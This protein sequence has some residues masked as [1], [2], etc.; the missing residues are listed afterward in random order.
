MNVANRLLHGLRDSLLCAATCLRLQ[1]P[2]I[3]HQFW[4]NWYCTCLYSCFYLSSAAAK[5]VAAVHCSLTFNTEFRLFSPYRSKFETN[6]ASTKA[7]FFSGRALRMTKVA[8]YT[9]GDMTIS[10][11]AAPQN[12]RPLWFPGSQAPE[13]LDGRCQFSVTCRERY[14]SVVKLFKFVIFYDWHSTTAVKSQFSFF[15]FIS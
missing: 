4:V 5:F 11:V 15:R 14:I 9:N 7:S 12:E 2:T 8:A 13:W 6:V 1:I 10:A 3:A